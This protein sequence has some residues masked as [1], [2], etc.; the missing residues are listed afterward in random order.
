MKRR[1]FTC[2]FGSFAFLF[3]ISLSLIALWFGVPKLAEK[4]F[5]ECSEGL[6]ELQC[7]VYG[8]RI[9]MH[10]TSLITSPES[11]TG[12]VEFLVSQGESVASIA[13]R[14]ENQGVIPDGE[15]FLNY[16]IYKGMD[17]QIKSGIYSLSESLSPIQIAEEIRS[18][19]Q[20]ISLFIYPGWR[21]EEIAAALPNSGIE[22]DPAEFLEFVGHPA[23]L[24]EKS[25]VSDFPNAEGFL[26]PGEYEIPRKISPGELVLTLV[27]RTESNLTPEI[28]EGFYRHG[29]NIYQGVTLASIIQRESYQVDE[30]A[31]IA[32]VFYNR[33]ESGMRLE[34]DP[35]VQYALGYSEKWGDWWKTPLRIGDL[36]IDSPY[37]TYLVYGLP[38]TPIANP[39]LSALL[40][41][42]FP[43]ETP[44]YFFRAACDNSGY[45]QFSET[46]EEH[47]AKACK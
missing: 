5:G 13:A 3:V 6:T 7:R 19:K 14:L 15:D 35:T 45:H 47:T 8:S 2:L 33:L 31:R 24:P 21:A 40:A 11:S 17:S 34:T 32:S 26:F 25:I 37:N 10:K 30:R 42:A 43:E 28:V 20:V 29:L 18:N 27:R 41:A 46:F 1:S 22:V 36:D 9:L 4:D 12:E 44:Y 16:L 23:R 39:D 38:P